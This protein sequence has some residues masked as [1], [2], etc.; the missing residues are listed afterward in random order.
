MFKFKVSIFITALFFAQ[1]SLANNLTLTCPSVNS[2]KSEG[3]TSADDMGFD[4]R[5]YHISQYDSQRK[6]CFY[7]VLDAKNENEAIAL[8]NQYLSKLSGNPTPDYV[9]VHE[10]SCLYDDILIGVK[11]YLAMADTYTEECKH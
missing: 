11:R 9:G 5:A 10:A 8:G 6:W 3:L 4:Y 7:I 2:I 1:V